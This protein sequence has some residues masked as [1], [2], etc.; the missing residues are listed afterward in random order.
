M[1]KLPSYVII[2]VGAVIILGIVGYFY[3]VPIRRTAREI[4]SLEDQYQ[5]T[6]AT[7]EGLA[8][9]QA[10]LDKAKAD[11][12]EAEALLA[13][14]MAERSIPISFIYPFEATWGVLWPEYQK[15]L[16]NL[17]RAYVD[18]TKCTLVSASPLPAPPMMPPDP[19][20]N[21]L[22]PP[23][24]PPDPPANGF[25]QV[26]LNQSISLTL[27][28]TLPDIERFYR[29]L[30]NFPRVVTVDG[31][32]LQSTGNGERLTANVNLTVYL[33]VE[34]PEAPPPRPEPALVDLAAWG[35]VQECLEPECP[36]QGWAWVAPA[37]A[38]EAHRHQAANRA[39]PKGQ[40]PIRARVPRRFSYIIVTGAIQAK[41]KKGATQWTVTARPKQWWQEA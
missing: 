2:I 21:G 17:I 1:G 31:L 28:G 32:S 37:R 7:A 22:A 41:A 12:A 25:L 8:A 29:S 33:L 13:Q 5:S 27:E 38:W 40:Q 9:A 3:F 10:A 19:P 39:G 4:A 34:V 30:R 15:N 26:P 23:M 18:Q 6:K 14:K 11:A 16:P 35:W 20:A 24:M 36:V